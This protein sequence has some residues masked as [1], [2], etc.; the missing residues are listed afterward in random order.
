MKSRLLMLLTFIILGMGLALSQTRTVQGVV[1]SS[2]DGLPIVGAS[3]VVDGT[4]KGTVT[5]LDGKFILENVSSKFKTLVV[6]YI[7]MKT[8]HCAIKGGIMKIV[9]HSDTEE[10]DEVVVV[11]YG[12]AKKQSLVGAQSNIS[13]KQIEKRPLT[14][15]TSAFT[16]A[17]PGVQALTTSGQPGS[18]SSLRIRGFGSM[19]ASDA[20]IYVVDGSVF[21]GNL[22][23]INPSDIQSVSILKDAASTSLYGSSAGNGVILITTK[24]GSGILGAAPSIQ[25]TINKG[26]TR[27]GVSDYDK[28]DAYEYY[29]L[30]W[31]QWYNQAKYDW[32]VD[33]NTAAGWA[34]QEVMNDLKYVPYNL[35]TGGY[36]YH[37]DTKTFTYDADAT[38][39]GVIPAY[40]LPDGTLNPQITSLLYGED[41]D[42]GKELFR[43]GHRNEYNINGS[44]NNDKVKSYVS[45]NYLNEQGY[46]IKTSFERFAGRARLEYNINKYLSLGQNIGVTRVHN[47]APRKASG[48][49]SANGFNFKR[50]IAPI[51]PI[52]LHN[53]DGT[54][55]LDPAG[56]PI[57]DYHNKRPYLGRYNPVASARLDLSCYDRDAISSRT[58]AE[59]NFMPGLKFRSNLAYDLVRLTSKVRFNNIMG[60][61][62]GH[63]L[64]EIDNGRWS[65]ITFNQLL[66]YQKSFQKHNFDVLFGHESYYYRTE[67]SNLSKKN[68]AVLG[69]DEM[70]N[71]IFPLDMG[72][73]TDTYTKEGYFA[74]I[75]YDYDMKYNASVSYRRDGSSRFDK[76]N[77]WGNFW[78][79]GLGWNINQEEFMK[80]IEW[81][82]MLK[83]RGSIGQTG[84][85]AIG[86]YYAY[87]TLY[88]LDWNNNDKSG[89]R[90]NQLANKDLKWETQTSFDVAV[91]FSV[92]NRLRGTL[93]FFNKQSKD[94]IFAFPLSV[95]TG[96]GS[97]DRNIGK[98][99][100]YGLEF[101]LHGTIFKNR[102]WRWS[103][104]VN[105]TL[106]KNEIVRLPEANRELGIET[107]SF[108]Y[109][110]GR[111]MFDF[112]LPEWIGV[113]PDTG[114]AMYRIDDVQYPEL[115]NPENSNFVGVAKEGE[116]ATWTEDGRFAKKHYCGSSIPD[117]YGGFG[118]ELQWKNFDL[119]F[120]FAYQ[121]GGKGYDGAYQGLMGRTLNGG[122]AKHKDMLK[123]WR[124]PGQKT[125][126]PML[127]AGKAGEYDNKSS[128]RFLI[129]NSGL[130]LKSVSLGY[131]VPQKYIYKYGIKGLRLNLAAENLFLLSKR[132]GFNPFNSY[133]GVSGSA[134]YEMSK[135]LT[136]SLILNF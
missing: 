102:D 109:L 33:N 41:M 56:E 88:S 122:T 60:D 19:N 65:T 107:G 94:L 16:G 46:R 11:A 37:E 132:K 43:T 14:N 75:N 15:V 64:L 130:M 123:A 90:F 66:T 36:T 110:E 103:V 83:L 72:S 22:S 42:W 34:M 3:V 10:L 6:S 89:V 2:D 50:N 119:A 7:G 55:V 4:T 116:A 57:Y 131:E 120:A 80:D 26:L 5:D 35:V 8:H 124:E 74:R 128:D 68:M 27:M 95:S 118:T 135:T 63:G 133:S 98:V 52:H 70:S 51:Y 112:Y 31:Q 113:N 13:S 115:A 76:D 134:F 93:E 45:F 67:S 23:D 21:G 20:P 58:F 104:N 1:T 9:L 59:I 69:I 28:V 82:D 73:N 100:N 105:G 32:G 79:L 78:S 18:S 40:V 117:I 54:Y 126:V 30:L 108:K 12:T 97:I 96:I 25:V 129:D 38:G 86:T 121:I 114:K 29:P 53:P 44:Y 84:N 71:F 39:S 106:L 24:S 92:F 99:K 48:S 81:L 61:Q 85:D 91:E 17:A 101:D 77:R 127:H 136:A 111:S 125:D 49:W 62:A 47:K 87:Q